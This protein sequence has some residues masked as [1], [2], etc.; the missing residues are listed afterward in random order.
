MSAIDD[1]FVQQDPRYP[2]RYTI[3]L[4]TPNKHLIDSIVQSNLL[5]SSTV[6]DDYKSFMFNAASVKPLNSFLDEQN[7]RLDH[8]VILKMIYCLSTQLD[9]L[10]RECKKSFAFYDIANI[11][12]ID[13]NK[14]VYV[15]GDMVNFIHNSENILIT[16]P[17]IK[18]DNLLSPELSNINTIPSKI[19]YK[20]IYYSLGIL[21]V[22][23]M[24][25]VPT[26]NIDALFRDINGTKLHGF[27]KRCLDA[28]PTKRSLLF[29]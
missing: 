20:S 1:F 6:C 4:P 19:H 24:T 29:V 7:G 9:F 18:T 14:F 3:S 23:C 15:S 27:I 26:G 12:V 28:D 22:F 2:T 8:G 16:K 10:I 5:F 25:G 17:F 21:I 13:N 11:I